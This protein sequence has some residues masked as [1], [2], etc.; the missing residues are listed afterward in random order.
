M[1][2]FGGSMNCVSFP[3][4]WCEDQDQEKNKALIRVLSVKFRKLNMTA[5]SFAL[6]TTREES[7]AIVNSELGYGYQGFPKAWMP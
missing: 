6:N 4:L 7:D 1:G 2:V 5:F 3:S